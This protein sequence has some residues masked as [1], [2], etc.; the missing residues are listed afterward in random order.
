MDTDFNF[1][2]TKKSSIP[3]YVIEFIQTLAVCLVVGIILYWQV[4]Q[5]HKVSGHSMD[6]TFHN[7]DYIITNKIGYRF[8]APK[9]GD[10]VVLNN[11][12]EVSE[13]FIKRIIAVPEERVKVQSGRVYI[14]GQLLNEPYLAPNLTTPPG[15]FLT[16]GTEV[17]VPQNNYIVFGDNRTASS[18]SREWGFVPR[19]DIIGQ[20]FLR[21]WPQDAV[22]LI[23]TTV[24]Y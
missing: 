10:V 9:R 19:E 8:H 23:P 16:E 24:N 1:G 3:S 2:E 17:V 18:D 22:G 12:R 4:A 6:P 14:N 7:N 21:Y 20:V 11:P 13:A 15:A 5:P